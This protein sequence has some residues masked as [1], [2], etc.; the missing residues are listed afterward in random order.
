MFGNAAAA[1]RWD[2][3]HSHSS[4][5]KRYLSPFVCQG[6][7]YASLLARPTPAPRAGRVVRS[8][9]RGARSGSPR[10]SHR[11]RGG[12]RR[13]LSRP[14][15]RTRAAADTSIDIQ[16][17]PSSRTDQ[18]MAP[19]EPWPV[20][21]SRGEST[22]GRALYAVELDLDRIEEVPHVVDVTQ[23]RHTGPGQPRRRH[24]QPPV[25]DLPLGERGDDRP[26][27]RPAR[28][29]RHRDSAATTARDVH[30]RVA[31]LDGQHRRRARRTRSFRGTRRRTSPGPEDE[32]APSAGKTIAAVAR[33]RRHLG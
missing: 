22:A 10:R 30:L 27:P 3:A 33:T 20:P 25:H 31:E 4:Q 19:Q 2:P 1:A 17:P 11:R 9:A 13:P 15:L 26:L 32:T 16:G 8:S 24:D 7:M 23:H 28:P 29:R 21:G 18:A 12:P 5:A 14:W 6:S